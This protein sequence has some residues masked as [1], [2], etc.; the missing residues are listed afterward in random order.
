MMPLFV[1]DDTSPRLMKAVVPPIVPLFTRVSI[2]EEDDISA[3]LKLLPSAH[4]TSVVP[5]Q[6]TP[7][8]FAPAEAGD[9]VII[10]I[11]AAA[12][13][14]RDVLLARAALIFTATA[15]I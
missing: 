14:K 7:M 13:A 5:E 8:R 3:V 1:I 15:L 12:Y 11:V 2:E 6:L 10:P 9:E 4:T